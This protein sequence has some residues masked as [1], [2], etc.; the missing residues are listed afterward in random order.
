MRWSD[1]G[2]KLLLCVLCVLN[3]LLVSRAE[4]EGKIDTVEGVWSYILQDGEAPEILFNPAMRSFRV[5]KPLQVSITKKREFILRF[6]SP[7]PIGKVKIWARLKEVSQVIK[8]A[9]FESVP[10]FSEYRK[11]L[12]LSGKGRIWETLSGEEIVL[13]R[14]DLCH[15]EEWDLWIDCI[16]PLYRKLTVTPC[17]WTVSFGF[18]KGRHW[19]PLLPAHAREAV[20]IALNMAYLFSSSEFI[21]RLSGQEGR[22]Y[23][24]NKRTKVNTKELIR[25]IYQLPALNYGHATGVNGLGGGSVIGLNEWCYLAHYADDK[26]ITHTIFHEFAHCLGYTHAGNMT[27]ENGLGK[28][29]VALCGELY[30]QMCIRQELPVYSRYFLDTRRCRQRYGNDFYVESKQMIKKEESGREKKN[31]LYRVFLNA[32]QQNP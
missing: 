10:A 5:D 21:S 15:P 4:N 30:T 2:G 24:D 7:R 32:P 16:D 14:K 1:C 12:D 11:Q 18:Y 23:S 31:E 22:L 20:A 9:E 19:T 26:G 28:G 6:Y 17:K 29:W 13:R 27:Y 8:I 25:R 3:G